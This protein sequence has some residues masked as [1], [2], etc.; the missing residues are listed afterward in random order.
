MKIVIGIDQSYKCTGMSIAVDGHIKRITCLHLEKLEN[1][2]QKRQ[3]LKTRLESVLNGC[4]MRSSNVTVICER[5]RLQSQGFINI[6]YIKSIGALNSVIVDV[7]KSYNVNVYS[8]DT[9]AWKSSI[10]GTSKPQQNKYGIA[11]EKY[12]T[13]K[14]ICILGFKEQIKEQVTNRKKKGVICKNGERYILNDDAADSAC[15]ALYGFAKN[16]KL[17]EEH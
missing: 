3:A 1:N 11:P 12:R 10:V 2:T 16:P 5:I 7:A 6:D 9:R 17:K 15:I 13:I 8:A 4:L 14:F